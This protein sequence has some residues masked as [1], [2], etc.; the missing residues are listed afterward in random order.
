MI[1]FPAYGGEF[2]NE[3]MSYYISRGITRVF[4]TTTFVEMKVLKLS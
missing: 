2:S 4:Q 1:G 3:S